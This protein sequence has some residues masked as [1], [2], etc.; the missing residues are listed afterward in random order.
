MTQH[1]EN[2]LFNIDHLAHELTAHS[3]ILVPNRRLARHITSAWGQHC[4]QQRQRAWRQAPVQTLDAWLLECWRQLQDR[5]YPDGFAHSI[6]SPHAE[7]LI[8]EQLIDGDADNPIGIDGVAFARLA[9]AALQN[10][11]RWQVPFTELAHSAHEASRHLLRWHKMFAAVLANKQLLTLAQAQT[12][13][14]R[15]FE[16]GFLSK[17]MRVV[18]VGFNT[19]LAPLYQH[20]INAAFTESIN[21]A[22]PEKTAPKTICKASNDSD[23]I[24]QAALWAKNIVD[25][26]GQQRVGIVFPNLAS[27]RHRVDRIFRDVFTPTYCLPDTPHG[28]PPFNIS[29][30]IALGDTA[31]ISSA[32]HLLQLQRTPQPLE[33]YY[34]L[35]ND[36]FWGDAAKEQSA[37]ARCQILLRK[38]YKLQPGS[39]DLRFGMKRAEDELSPPADRDR[40]TDTHAAH[41]NTDINAKLSQRLQQFEDR[42]RRQNLSSSQKNNAVTKRFTDWAEEFS[43]RLNILGWPGTRTLDSIEYQQQTLWL[44]MLVEFAGLDSAIDPVD[45]HTALTQLSRLC[46]SRIFQPEGS[47]SPVQVLGLLEAAGLHFDQLWLAE[48]HDGQWP[49]TPDYNPLLPVAL[50]RLHNMPRSSAEAEIDIARQLL[51]DFERHCTALVFSFA[52][53]D[54]D[55]ER[56]LSRLLDSHLLSRDLLNRN[57]PELNAPLSKGHA[58]LSDILSSANKPVLQQIAIDQGPALSL[59]DSPIRGGSGI[60]RDQARCPFNAFAIW[61]LG[62]EALPEPTFGFSPIERGV[63]VHHALEIFWAQCEDSDTLNSMDEAGRSALLEQSIATA[64]NQAKKDRP[65]LFG[66]RFSTIESQRLHALLSSWLDIEQARKAFSVSARE[67]KIN[68]QLGEL[69]LSLRIDRID[70]LEDGSIMLIDYKTG[71]ASIKGFADE[72]PEEPQLLLYALATE[73]ETSEQSLAAL[74]FAQVSAGKGVALKGVTNQT[75]LAPGLSDLEASGLEKNWALTLDLW[76]ERLTSLAEEFCA[77]N[78]EMAFYSQTAARYQSQLLPL[79]RWLEINPIDETDTDDAIEAGLRND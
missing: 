9:Q 34:S 20:I 1:R 16:Q 12:F 42:C 45:S 70:Q 62:A 26:Q 68:F 28:L 53:R 51:S 44:D 59:Q 36:P 18:L 58:L 17:S 15:A 76:R 63:L 52:A 14:W 55:S 8:W 24:T 27:Q 40:D 7:R 30:G 66:P 37:R 32:L 43:T 31:L 77:G 50:Q 67:Q 21:W 65:D 49:Q 78:A 25:T 4:S 41:T 22:E 5:A 23:E 56:Q 48:M 71:S 72:R 11:E 46:R 74:A 35:L 60:L 3:Q 2:P 79:N 6:I 64:I 57:L 39:G 33:F 13:V 54:G 73:L 69:N 10:L 75:D 19:E 38:G 61:R 29:A 47:D